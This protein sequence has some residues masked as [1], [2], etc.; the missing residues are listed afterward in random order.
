MS[1]HN[2]TCSSASLK[3]H[4]MSTPSHA[5]DKS[6]QSLS[7]QNRPDSHFYTTTTTFPHQTRACIDVW[8][9][10]G[11]VEGS[12]IQQL[13]V[14]CVHNACT[15]QAACQRQSLRA[16]HSSGATAQQSSQRQQPAKFATKYRGLCVQPATAN[17]AADFLC[18]VTSRPQSFGFAVP[19]YM[20]KRLQETVHCS[21]T[22]RI[23]LPAQSL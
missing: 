23:T 17:A 3:T 21:P 22:L 20:P 4:C 7:D 1:G 5:A 12:G 6:Q 19:I 18:S 13:S 11:H 15:C 9:N 8:Y 14:I 16:R 2:Y 10:V